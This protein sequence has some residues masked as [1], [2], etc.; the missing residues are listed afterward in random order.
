VYG[1]QMDLEILDR[2]RNEL[3][4]ADGQKFLLESVTLR[5]G[6]AHQVWLS[7]CDGWLVA[8]QVVPRPGF[9]FEPISI[10]H[11]VQEYYEKHARAKVE[12]AKAGK[13]APVPVEGGRRRG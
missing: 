3:V 9:S 4:A 5:A 10:E 1:Y 8:Y 11:L 13:T 2:T 12:E 6:M 7:Y